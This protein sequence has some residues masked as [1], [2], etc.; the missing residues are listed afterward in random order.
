MQL[1]KFKSIE[2]QILDRLDVIW[3]SL[4]RDMGTKNQVSFLASILHAKRIFQ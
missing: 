2:K 4:S 3:V 1:G